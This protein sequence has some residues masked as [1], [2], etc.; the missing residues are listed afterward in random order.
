MSNRQA[1]PKRS[2]ILI[3]REAGM[4]TYLFIIGPEYNP[5]DAEGATD[6]WTTCNKATRCGDTGL[7]YV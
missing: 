5:E 1:M 4:A 3:I 6:W 7:V 2:S